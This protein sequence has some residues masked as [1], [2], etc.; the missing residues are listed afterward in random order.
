M[1]LKSKNS[2]APPKKTK[3]EEAK[4]INRQFTGIPGCFT[5]LSIVLRRYYRYLLYLYRR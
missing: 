2:T 1:N 4:S 3:E 5:V